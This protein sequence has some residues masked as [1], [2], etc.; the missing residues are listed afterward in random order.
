MRGVTLQGKHLFVCDGRGRGHEDK[1]Q[2]FAPTAVTSSAS[3]TRHQK[4]FTN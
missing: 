3:D 1:V 4:H 2:Y